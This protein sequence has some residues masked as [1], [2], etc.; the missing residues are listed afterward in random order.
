MEQK[1]GKGIEPLELHELQ[2]TGADSKTIETALDQIRHLPLEII[3]LNKFG[4]YSRRTDLSFANFEKCRSGLFGGKHL[5][6]N[7]RRIDSDTGKVKQFHIFDIEDVK[8]QKPKLYVALHS[9]IP[10]ANS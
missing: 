1:R 8:M 9:I 6:A 10:W 3:A 7:F 5:F 2:L 4:F